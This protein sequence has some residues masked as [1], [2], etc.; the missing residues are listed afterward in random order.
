MPDK[1]KRINE[2]IDL[3]NYLIFVEGDEYLLPELLDL[4]K[5]KGES[6]CTPLNVGSR[7]HIKI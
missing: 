3:L 4:I 1:Q 7:E 2:D 5:L 6:K